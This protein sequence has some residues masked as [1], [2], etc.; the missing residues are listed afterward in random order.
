MEG[1]NFRLAR[2]LASTV[3]MADQETLAPKKRRGPKPSGQGVP[4]NVRLLPELL[5]RVDKWI[6]AQPDPKPSRP[7]AIRVLLRERLGES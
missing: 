7:E 2:P 6:E 5:D 1:T 4:V 3:S